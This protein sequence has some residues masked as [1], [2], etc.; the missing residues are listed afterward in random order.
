MCGIGLHMMDGDRGGDPR[1]GLTACSDRA[2]TR[3][4]KSV[5]DSPSGDMDVI[6]EED[7]AYNQNSIMQL[8]SIIMGVTVGSSDSLKRL[9]F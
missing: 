1:G 7:H 9:L 8:Y 4:D 5:Q 3:L 2:S 6:P